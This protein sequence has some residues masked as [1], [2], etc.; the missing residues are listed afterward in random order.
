MNAPQLSLVT[1]QLSLITPQLNLMTSEL[2]LVTSRATR[3]HQRSLWWFRSSLCLLHCSLS[4]LHCFYENFTAPMAGFRLTLGTFLQ[5]FFTK[6][7][8][9]TFFRVRQR[10]NCSCLCFSVV[11]RHFAPP[12][13]ACSS[14]RVEPLLTCW[15]LDP[16]NG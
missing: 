11:P 13:R 15:F 16:H 5:S 8:I 9:R 6:G 12:F 2:P 3:K 14:A 7:R 10:N 1:S 4:S